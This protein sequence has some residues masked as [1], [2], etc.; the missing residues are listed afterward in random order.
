VITFEDLEYGDDGLIVAVIQ[1]ANSSDVLMVGY[2]NAETLRATIASGF[3]HFWSRSRGK[4]WKKGET[5]GNTLMLHEIREDCDSDA[6][7]V[8]VEPAGPV[9]HTGADTCFGHRAAS[10]LGAVIDMLDEIISSRSGEDP[11]TSYTAR[12]IGDSDLAARKVLEEAGEVAFAA[13][14][15][16]A[17][18]DAQRLIEETADEMY[19]L[20]A[21]LASHGVVADGVAQELRSRMG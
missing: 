16:N 13:K 21:L 19:H 5:S 9:C 20:L 3:V 17:G 8:I 14:D 15:I 11:A 12:L 4:L 1:D 7:L 18:G 2:M 10:S 6:L